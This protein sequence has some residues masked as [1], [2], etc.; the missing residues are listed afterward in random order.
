[1]KISKYINKFALI[2]AL[3]FCFGCNSD[4]GW[5]CIKTAGKIVQQEINVND[6]DKITVWDRTKLIIQQGTEQKVVIETGENLLRKV[7]VSVEDGRLGIHNNNRCNLVRDYEITKVYVTTPNITE[8]RSSTGYGI[9]SRG[10]L[11]FPVLT[12]FSEDQGSAG[13]NH[14]S[15]DF[16]LDL[17]VENLH[18]VAN[19]RSKFYLKGNTN[20]TSFGLYAGDCRIYAEDLIIQ[21]LTI[22]HRSTGPM[23]VNPQNSIRGKI[24]SLG[25]V[26]SKNRPPNVE[27]EEL[28]KGRLVFE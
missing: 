1:M 16:V 12:L 6:F 20:Q 4:S 3:F 5:D 2:V 14:T 24:I 25:N 23:V 18:I 13:T 21:D 27:V 17:D 11:K 10:I 9:E 8:I 26:I 19:G 28:Y 15:G 7:T 22:F